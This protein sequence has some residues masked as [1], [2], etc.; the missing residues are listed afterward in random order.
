[1]APALNLSEHESSTHGEVQHTSC[2]DF[3]GRFD[4]GDWRDTR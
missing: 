2:R 3:R 1:M 4:S